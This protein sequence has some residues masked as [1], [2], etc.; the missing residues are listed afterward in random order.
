MMHCI[1]MLFYFEDAKRIK[2]IRKIDQNSKCPLQTD[3]FLVIPVFARRC[4]S[5]CSNSKFLSADP[6]I[7]TETR[8][9][10]LSLD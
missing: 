3:R 9:N 2:Q 10:N 1:V 6:R 7:H 8:T 5:I 4:K